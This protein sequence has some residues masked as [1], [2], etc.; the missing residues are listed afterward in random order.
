MARLDRTGKR[1]RW[2]ES[3]AAE[4]RYNSQL[5]Q[6]ARQVGV[7]VRGIA[8][9]GTLDRVSDLLKALT[10]YA[11]MITPWAESVAGFM[12][13][14]VARRD[15]KMWRSVSQDLGQRIR[16]EILQA[17]TGY[18][19]RDLQ[20]EQVDLIK[21][22]PLDAAERVHKFS[23][24]AI[25]KSTRAN[26]IAAEIMRSEAVS[27]NKATLIARTEVSRAASNFVQARAMAAGSEGYIWRTSGDGD[28]RET[29]QEMEGKYVR[30]SSPPKTDKSLPPYHAGCGP[31]CRCF[32]EPIFPDF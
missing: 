23:M 29:H 1:K 15:E 12:I 9:G 28:V 26:D 31:N 8:P 16:R 24:E 11:A 25:S 6:V 21:S 19:L 13:A 22:I 3:R 18:F 10:E 4:A 30:W 5:Q 14:D 20:R 27:K 2:T 32:A 7:L 17:P